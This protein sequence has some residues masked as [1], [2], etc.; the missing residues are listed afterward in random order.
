MKYPIKYQK[1]LWFILKNLANLQLSIS[2]LMVI[3]AVSILGTVIEQDQ[4]IEFYQLNYP[5]GTILP[6]NLIITTGLNHIFFTKWFICIVFIFALSISICSIS[7]QLPILKLSKKLS[8]FS[9]KKILKRK[10][11]YNNDDNQ[12]YS[13]YL[14]HLGKGNYGLFLARNK[15]Y[16]YKGIIGRFA[17]IIVHL[18]ML[19]ILF[20]AFFGFLNGYTAQEMVPEHE[21]A[22]IQNLTAAGRLS[23]VPQNLLIQVDKFHID[24]NSNGTP[25]Q[26]Y[27]NVNVFKNN[28]KVSSEIIYVNKPLKYNDLFIYQTDWA[29]NGIRLFINGNF[30]QIPMTNKFIAN[31]QKAWTGS[32]A[33]NEKNYNFVIKQLNGNILLY[34]TNGNFIENIT[35][36]INFKLDNYKASV[37]S[38]LVS[39]G[40]QIK[41]DSGIPI[42]YLGF[43]LLMI[44]SLLSYISFSQIWIAKIDS[45][46]VAT[47]TTNRSVLEF[48]RDF[49]VIVQK[50]LK[51]KLSSR[52]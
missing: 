17:P 32:L 39:S 8:F 21:Y 12:Q 35:V 1:K 4:P 41:S 20:G 47:G 7:R 42:V 6:W 3:A 26:Y 31:N 49:Y 24:Y 15:I 25:S 43:F 48:E 2:L 14:F 22:H 18:S 44:S 33:I 52:I 10:K 16:A 38:I 29:I 19:F 40:L 30:I 23:K 51:E 11:I 45:K 9:T 36:G 28:E 37:D 27:S 5:E 50:V 46:T 34:D 13:N